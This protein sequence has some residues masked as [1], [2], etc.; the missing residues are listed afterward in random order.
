MSKNIGKV[1]EAFKQCDD[2]IF[3]EHTYGKKEKA[4]Y[5]YCPSLC[6]VEY[7]NQ[8]IL[9][10]MQRIYQLTHFDQCSHIEEACSIKLESV[11]ELS[12][13]EINKHIFHGEIVLWMDH[14][15]AGYSFSTHKFPERQ[16]EE[17]NIE[18][19]VRGP[20]DGLIENIETNIGLIRKRLPVETLALQTYSIGTK[21]NTKVCLLYE[22]EKISPS[23]V[24]DIQ[25]KLQGITEQIDELVSAT[26]LEELISDNP[27][28]VFPLTI[29]SGRPDFIVSCLLKGRFAILIDG[30]PGALVAPAT[31]SLQLKT[32][33]DNH[34]NFL[35]TS[36]GRILRMFSLGISILLPSFYVSLTGFH[37]DQIPFRLL[38]T[39][40]LSRMGI[41]FSIPLE[42]FLM[43]FLMEVFR[44]AGY[45][46][47]SSIGQSITVVGGL[48]IGDAAIRAGLV[49]PTLVVTVAASVVAGSTLISQALTGTVSVLRFIAVILASLLGMFGFVLSFMIVVTYLS[50]L[51]SFGVPYLAPLS[52][53]NLKDV[54]R[55][56]LLYPRKLKGF[57]P[58]YLKKK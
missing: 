10:H 17:T 14:L 36:F 51:T 15:N 57:K 34:F 55:S 2:V 24:T 52:P 28:S 50:T 47:P 11:K 32:A 54:F 6:D 25:N 29:Y 56:I 20:R 21:T 26:Q 48:I 5:I 43:L 1:K 31:L 58:Q 19:S 53:L 18:V 45:R 37:L 12:I 44:E 13:R 33:E 4:M 27:Y 16:T 42:V 35:S 39:I 9:P 22:T 8:V 40:A 3:Y 30:V 38:A 23:V 41:P 46:L 7:L 49:S